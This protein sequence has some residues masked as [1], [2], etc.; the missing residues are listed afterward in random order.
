VSAPFTFYEFFA[1]GGM[2]RAGLGKRWQ[3]LFANDF[4]PLK[5]DTYRAN[6]GGDDLHVGDVWRVNTPQLPGTPDL[7]WASSPCQ[8][9]SL[10]GKRAGLDGKRSSAFWGFWRLVKGL[11]AEGRA[12]RTIVIE[13]VTGLL[14][15]HNGA[16]FNALCQA[17]NDENYQF[18]AV[19]IDA[20][21]FL[22]QSRPRMFLIATRTKIENNLTQ[23]EPTLPL[24]PKKVVSAF[25]H[26]PGALQDRWVWWTGAPPHGPNL[27][28]A[29]ILENA[30][31]VEWHSEFETKRTLKML[32]PLH[33]RK[34]EMAKKR[35]ELVFGAF[36]RRMRIEDG[37]PVQRAELRFDGL[38]GCLRTPGGGSSKQ[39]IISVN[40]N[41]VKTRRLTPRE[42]ARLMGLEDSYIL[43]N[44][45]N[46]ALKVLGDGVAV[47]AASFVGKRFIELLIHSD[48]LEGGNVEAEKRIRRISHARRY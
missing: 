4:D 30:D 5:A 17:L 48:R 31:E 29:S 34:L 37:I 9:L 44:R 41:S 15:S 1:G 18:G 11:N 20:A 13:N 3:C 6:W 21:L 33:L 28:L 27:D 32:S 19:E 43:P 24:H 22:P 40:Q 8:D 47:P 23:I 12:P 16:D 10:A 39:F 14:T 35:N 26:L 42:S 36:Y 25:N 46:T 7:V 38:A 45:A 2:A